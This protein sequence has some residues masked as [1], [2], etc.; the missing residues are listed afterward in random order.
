MDP[1][2]TLEQFEKR[3]KRRDEDFEFNFQVSL[4]QGLA[5]LRKTH[6]AEEELF[7]QKMQ[8]KYL[9]LKKEDEE[10]DEHVSYMLL[11][12]QSTE[13]NNSKRF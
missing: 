6:K 11:I 12:C 1:I 3:K 2:P 7:T 9:Q 8:E 10:R 13:I 5:E 4:N